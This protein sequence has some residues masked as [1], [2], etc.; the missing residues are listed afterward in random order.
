MLKVNA[1]NKRFALKDAKQAKQ[2]NISDSRIKGRY[3]YAVKNMTFSCEV[4]EI[5]G[6]LGANGAGKTSLLRLLSTALQPD[7]GEIEFN[8]KL[9]ETNL[10]D[11]RK[12]LGFLSGSTGL[13]EKL[14]GYENLMYFANLYGLNKNEAE[15]R[16]SLL[17]EALNMSSFLPRRFGDYSTGMKQKLAIARA[18]IHQPK[19]I[20]LDEPTTGLD[21]KAREIILEFIENIR[22]QG[23]CVIFSTHDLA[24]VERL[25]SKVLVVEQGELKFD[26]S[27]EQLKSVADTANLN[28]ALFSFMQADNLNLAHLRSGE[29]NA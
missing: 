17:S 11:Y 19:L 6:V 15:Q 1:L 12:Q 21:I 14:T 5:T 9:I 20:I 26:G 23:V 25:C 24:E 4:G 27:L 8:Q 7:S 28:Q 29:A 10:A 2:N 22:Q 3:F 18:M 16:I 13:Y